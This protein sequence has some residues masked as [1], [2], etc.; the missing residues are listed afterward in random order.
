[1]VSCLTKDLPVYLDYGLDIPNEYV[2]FGPTQDFDVYKE[3]VDGVVQLKSDSYSPSIIPSSGLFPN[4][5]CSAIVPVSWLAGMS[6]KSTASLLK[7]VYLTN[8]LPLSSHI[9]GGNLAIAH[10]Q[11]NAVPTTERQSG[12]A[13]QTGF[14]TL[15]IDLQE[16]LIQVFLNE[17]ITN[18]DNF[19]GISEFNHMCPGSYGPLRSDM[20]KPCPQEYTTDEK[21]DKCYS[22]QESVWGVELTAKLEDIKYKF[23]PDNLFKCYG[24]IQPK[25]SIS[26]DI[27][28]STTTAIT[29]TNT[30]DPETDIRVEDPSLVHGES[31]NKSS[32]DNT[33]T[34]VPITT[35]T[36]PASDI[37][38]KD[39]T[40]VVDGP[41]TSSSS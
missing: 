22:M 20:T 12:V 26:N 3:T 8:S 27:A 33:T 7:E 35:T 11:M 9:T 13:L 24:C 38:A 17:A 14:D 36:D 5:S 2:K 31:L 29:V 1:M 37:P 23:D 15:P 4:F 18:G 41:L 21:D 32:S 10:D 30:T 39:P 25:K 34:G 28:T 19:P 40:P 16:Q 6:D